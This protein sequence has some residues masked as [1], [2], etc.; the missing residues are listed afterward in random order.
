[1]DPRLRLRQAPALVSRLIQ[2]PSWIVEGV[3]ATRLRRAVGAHSIDLRHYREFLSD[4]RQVVQE[5]LGV[6]PE[7]YEA[8]KV[9]FWTPTRADRDSRAHWDSRETLQSLVNVVVRLTKPR[10]MVE[11]G[12]ARGFTSAITL[13]AMRDLG[14]GHLYSVDLPALEFGR[15]VRVGEAVPE[16]LRTDWT[17]ELGPSRLVL[18]DLLPRVRPVDV[19]LHDSDHSY[20]YQLSEYRLAWPHIRQG[21]ILLS[22]DVHNTAFVRFAGEVGVRPCLLG[23]ED[24][25]AAVGLI[26]KD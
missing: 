8:A 6:T 18:R 20:P 10:V 24:A 9:A 1:M 25:R 7:A 15:R 22:D 26:V 13:A 19:F 3:R 2:H 11:T 23:T 14:H 17:I 5:V 21:G 16:Y 4:E 12:V